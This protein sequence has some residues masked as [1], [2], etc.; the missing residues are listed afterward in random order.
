MK[1]TVEVSVGR[2]EGKNMPAEEVA[3]ALAEELVGANFEVDDSSYTV[4]SATVVATAKAGGKEWTVVGK[5]LDRWCGAYMKVHPVNVGD[6]PERSDDEIRDALVELDAAS[7]AMLLSAEVGEFA[8][9][10]RFAK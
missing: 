2:D 4:D 7:M 9:K 10:A 6:A 8:R 3:E 5:L 1:V